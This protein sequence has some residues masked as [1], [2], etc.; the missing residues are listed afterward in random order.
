MSVEVA[1]L[2]V[3]AS[4]KTSLF[5]A[6]A[7]PHADGMGMLDVPDPRL[8]QLT[9]AVKPKKTTAAQVRVN[10]APV[11]SRARQV[12]AAREAEVVIAVARC[13]GPDADPAGELESLTLDMVL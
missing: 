5:R 8:D 13:F 2:G 11:G 3:P 9:A 12:A 1:I 4:G 10:D 6:L 7:G